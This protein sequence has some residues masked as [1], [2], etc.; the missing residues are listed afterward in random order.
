VSLFDSGGRKLLAT[1]GKQGV[2]HVVDRTTGALRFKLPVTTVLN[3]DAPLTA[4]GVRV[5]PVAGVQWNGAAH[6]PKSRLLYINAIDWCSV[7]KLGPEPKWEA[8]VPYTGLANGWGANDPTSEW[9]GWINA[10]D[11]AKGT[12]AWRVKT[13]SPM[14]AAIT[15]TA[16]D[17][18]FTGNLEGDLL[19]LDARNGRTLYRF[20]RRPDCR[21]NRHLG[22]ARTPIRRSRLRP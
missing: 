1:S 15:P 6:S 20:N 13:P 22:T 14:Y 18:L 17:V 5:C 21:R 4:E 12:M 10:V 9:A 19:V 11:P 7:F 2:L 3:Q 8:T 16:G